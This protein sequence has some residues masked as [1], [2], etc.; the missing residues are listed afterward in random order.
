MDIS[1][2]IITTIGY[3]IGAG[4]IV[5]WFLER[6]KFNA[7]VQRVLE[8]V[9]STRIEN[10]V[11]LSHHYKELLDDLKARYEAR[12]EEYS[13]MVNDKVRVLKD[14]ITLLRKQVRSLKLAM[15]EQE[16]EL[17]EKDN[18]IKSLKNDNSSK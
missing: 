14:E 15:K 17:K 3:L 4:G 8:E 9:N 12:Y 10:D 13:Q 7:E 1:T 11:K 6:R 18:I 5:F 2:I 16:K